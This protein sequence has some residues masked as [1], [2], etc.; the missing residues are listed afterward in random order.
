[1]TILVF[2]DSNSHGSVAVGNPAQ[3]D[4]FPKP[5]RWPEVMVT[6]LRREVIVEGQPGRTTVL[7]DPIEGAHKN[8]MRALPILLESHKPLDLVVVMLG[9]N[10]CKAR[11]GLRGYDIAAGASKLAQVVMAS[12]AGPRLAAPDVMLV[13]PVPV[14]ESG[15]LAETFQGARARA[16]AIAPALEAEAR[17]LGLGFLDAGRHATVDPLDGVH[18]TREGHAALGKAAAD[19]VARRIRG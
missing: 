11:F 7:D 1:M 15:A 3:L 9:T 19:A 17:R 14:E 5:D 13:A 2:G 4:R 12:Q 10:D 8:G 6:L 16:R 18:L